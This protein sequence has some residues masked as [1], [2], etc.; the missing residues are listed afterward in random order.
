MADEEQLALLR[1]GVAEW[2]EWRKQNSDIPIDLSE[3]DLVGA[4]LTDADMRGAVPRGA[5]MRGAD[6]SGAY[7]RGAVLTEAI[8]GGTIFADTDLRP[9]KDS[10][11][12][13]I[14]APQ[15]S[16]STHCFARRAAF[17]RCSCAAVA[18]PRA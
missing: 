18:C 12:S 17:P 16:A 10:K 4:N 9:L 1:Q 2:N 6:L 15:P 14:I 5:D 13:F 3:A 8:L 7:L 11:P